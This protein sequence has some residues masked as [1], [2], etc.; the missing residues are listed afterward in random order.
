[1]LEITVDQSKITKRYKLNSKKPFDSFGRLYVGGI[2]SFSHKKELNRNISN[3]TGSLMGCLSQIELDGKKIGLPEVISSGSIK[4][5]CDWQ[6]P[7]LNMPCYYEESCTQQSDT[8][9]NCD[10]HNNKNCT[11][12][13]TSREQVIL[14][15]LFFSISKKISSGMV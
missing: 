15:T 13:S 9:L 11:S 2:E 12:E 7:C 1:M 6:Y 5:G 4:V 3:T 10:C 14:T 8:G